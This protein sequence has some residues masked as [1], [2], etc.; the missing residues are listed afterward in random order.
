MLPGLCTTVFLN[1]VR[2]VEVTCLHVRQMSSF[3]AANLS[4]EMD[5]LSTMITHL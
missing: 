2:H 4:L 3:D 5:V 1:Q